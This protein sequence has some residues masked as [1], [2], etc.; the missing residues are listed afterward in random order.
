M[1]YKP[2]DYQQQAI[3]H[4]H[5][6]PSAGLLLEMGLGKSSITLTALEYL[7]NSL[8]IEKVLIVAPKRVTSVTWKGEIEKWN[9]LSTLSIS[10]IIGTE[11]QRIAAYN[12]PADIYTVS[13]DNIAWLVHYIIKT[14]KRFPY[15]CMVIDEL[16]NFK[17]S[18][19]MRF[20]ALRKIVPRCQ[21]VIGLTGTPAPNQLLGLWAQVFLLDQGQRLGRTFGA[22]KDKYFD[23]GARNGH[24]VFSYAPKPG[25]EQQIYEA[26]SDICLSMKASDYLELPERI[27]VFEEVEL[28]SYER[29]KE[30]KRTEVLMLADDHELTPVNA[31][32]MYNKLLQ[33]CNG[34]V[35]KEDGSYE[36]VDSAKLDAICE[37][38]ESLD[39]EPVLIGYQFKSDYERMLQ[40][41]PHLVKLD[42]DEKIEAWNRRE[43]AVAVTQIQSLAY[44]IN[45]QDGG[46]HI[47]L[48][49]VGWD[50]E[51]YQQ[52]LARI[53]RQGVKKAVIAKHFIAKNSVEQVVLE[54][55]QQ[56]DM[57][58]NRLM[59][60]LTRHLY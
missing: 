59:E 5:D 49:G 24:V 47:F 41:M 20:K 54:R 16:S 60:A 9:H 3:Q 40:R 23:A 43:I 1:L 35:Y 15:D 52:F 19:S 2:H 38:V 17:N 12:Q 57:T 4:L 50:L 48:Y 26:I 58:Q 32:S 14:A 18:S 53:H 33:Y 34:A 13:R 21:R 56:K 25:A 28:Q 22:Y 44:G 45:L 7:I 37:D 46:N 29:Y 8:Q 51:I 10:R 11:K 36:V 31:A 39:G 6:N 42:S 30:F 55:L 27:D